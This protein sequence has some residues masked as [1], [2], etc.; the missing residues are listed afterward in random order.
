MTAVDGERRGSRDV[1][2][3]TV[4]QTNGCNK[5]CSI[6]DSATAMDS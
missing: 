4:S 6:T 1:P 5:K 2:W 3:K